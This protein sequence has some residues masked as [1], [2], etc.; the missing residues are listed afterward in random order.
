MPSRQTY[1]Q[2]SFSFGCHLENLNTFPMVSCLVHNG[3]RY[4]R[5]GVLYSTFWKIFKE[6]TF[7]TT[8][9]ADAHLLFSSCK[10]RFQNNHNLIEEN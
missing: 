8:I 2:P 6:T 9:F 4:T 5:V 10:L 1:E 3:L 7:E